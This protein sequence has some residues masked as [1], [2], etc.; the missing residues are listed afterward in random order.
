MKEKLN[1][2]TIDELS[3]RIKIPKRTIYSRTSQR[4]I[5]FIKLGKHLRF[6]PVAIDEWLAYHSH[7]AEYYP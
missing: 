7:E 4:T 3:E 5:P 2:L 1:L 6:D